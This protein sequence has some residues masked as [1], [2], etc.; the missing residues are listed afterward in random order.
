MRYFEHI[1]PGKFG[2]GWVRCRST[3]N[4][5]PY[6]EQLENT[7]FAKPKAIIHW[8]YGSLVETINS[9]DGKTKMLSPIAEV[10]GYT[11]DKLDAFLGN[12]GEP[13]GVAAYKPYHSSGEMYIHN[14]VGMVGVPMD[15][16]PDFPDDRGTVFLT[17]H[18]K[19][20]T[21]ILSKIVKHLNEDKTVIITSGL[22]KA[23]QR[24]GIEKILEVEY[25]GRKSLVKPI[26]VSA[27]HG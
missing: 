24:K 7:L 25:T 5:E 19:F 6:T 14:Y 11:F 22:L 23:L 1:K 21:E 4:A 13:Y 12:L 9:P 8:S 17:E 16:Y 20:D 10:A 2:G 26:H 18:A 3:S 27:V 15:L